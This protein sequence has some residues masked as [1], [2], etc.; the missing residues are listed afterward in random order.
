M[1]KTRDLKRRIRSIS[2]TRQLTK[3]MKM[4]SAAKM[5]RATDRIVAARPFSHNMQQVLKSLATRADLESHP[6]L[7]V[8]GTEKMEVLL[9]TGDKGLCGSF[10]SNINK[11]AERFIQAEQE[12]GD[13]TVTV[14]TVG[15]RGREYF[16]RR[17]HDIHRDWVEVLRSVEYSTAKEIAG[18]MI[19]RYVSGE[20]DAIYLVYNE[21]KSAITQSP[22]VE[23]LLPIDPIELDEG[24]TAEDYIYEPSAEALLESLLTRYVEVQ[25]FTALLESVAAEHAARMTAMDAATRN[26]GDLID[27]LTLHMNRVRQAA[28]TT[29]IIEIV[30]GAQAL[31]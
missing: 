24:Q 15:K 3:A 17:G 26:A 11:T 18:D 9:V 10:N 16:S 19:T 30:A 12:K 4:V 5:R 23:K 1:S 27:R 6:L 14:H 31:G 21:F 8:T 7:A 2:S 20:L 13:R 28:I 22:V 29:E 25:V